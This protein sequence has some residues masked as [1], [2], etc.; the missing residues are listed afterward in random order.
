MMG[1]GVDSHLSARV[2]RRKLHLCVTHSDCNCLNCHTLLF[3]YF[4]TEVC[5]VQLDG[6]IEVTGSSATYSFTGVGSGI[7]GSGIS[8]YVCKMDGV[9]LPHCMLLFNR[10]W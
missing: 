8:G 4:I 1:H 6:Q 10:G 7:S 2:V 5:T 9:I 3:V